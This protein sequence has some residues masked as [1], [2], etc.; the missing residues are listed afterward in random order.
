MT[1]TNIYMTYLFIV[2]DKVEWF[3]IRFRIFSSLAHSRKHF[4]KPSEHCRVFKCHVTRHAPCA[5]VFWLVIGDI[6]VLTSKRSL[7][8]W[9]IFV[10]LR[11]Y[12]GEEIFNREGFFVVFTSYCEQIITGNSYPELVDIL[13]V[14]SLQLCSGWLSK[15][16]RVL[17]IYNWFIWLIFDACFCVRSKGLAIFISFGRDESTLSAG[18]VVWASW[19]NSKWRKSN[20]FSRLSI[21]ACIHNCSHQRCY[22][23]KLFVSCKKETYTRKNKT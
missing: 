22:S 15:A 11:V 20:C 2:N 7:Y 18:I 6:I 13:G 16:N 23:C 19:E 9:M 12:F 4:V 5:A 3:A 10:V 21:S 1:Q 14:K 8:K 17:T